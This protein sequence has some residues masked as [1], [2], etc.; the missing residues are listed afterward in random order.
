M[1]CRSKQLKKRN[2]SQKNSWRTITVQIDK[3]DIERISEI[4]ARHWR[5]FSVKRL[6]NEN[7]RHSCNNNPVILTLTTP[8]REHQDLLFCLW[9]GHNPLYFL[10]L[11]C[12]PNKTNHFCANRNPKPLKVKH[13]VKTGGGGTPGDTPPFT[14]ATADLPSMSHKAVARDELP[15]PHSPPR[16]TRFEFCRLPAT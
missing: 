11:H 10:Y 3:M 2:L 5:A 9:I 16:S 15:A 12:K 8:K 1:I 7:T 13:I 4:K 14:I 6:E